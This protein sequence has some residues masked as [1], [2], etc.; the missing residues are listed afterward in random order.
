MNNQ[1]KIAQWR[2]WEAETSDPIRR[3][4]ADTQI[5]ILSTQKAGSLLKKTPQFAPKICN[6]CN[7]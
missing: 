2:T 4:F 5:A 3:I 1:A 6:N 7:S